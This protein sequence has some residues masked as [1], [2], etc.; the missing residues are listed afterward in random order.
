MAAYSIEHNNLIYG[1]LEA[2]CIEISSKSHNFLLCGIYRPPNSGND[3]WDL[4]ENTFDNLNNSSINDLIILGDF[5]CDMSN[6]TPTN[7]ISQLCLSYTLTQLID[8]HTHFTEHSSS[9]IDLILV[10]KPQNVTYNGVSSPFVP[11]LIRYHC[12]SLICLNYIKYKQKSYKR[13]VWI[14]EKGDYEKFRQILSEINWD[15]LFSINDINS[16]V[17]NITDAIITAAKDCI[18]N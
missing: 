12:P 17:D 11:D 15:D 7:K 9:L 10:S 4:I 8:E 1:D 2:L 14:Y 5:N 3:Y 13:H 16:T 6:L 18:P